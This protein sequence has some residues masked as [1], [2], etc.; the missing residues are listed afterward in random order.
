M[1]KNQLEK[2]YFSI[3]K[4]SAISCWFFFFRRVFFVFIFVNLYG[5]ETFLIAWPAGGSVMWLTEIAHEK[6]WAEY[7]VSS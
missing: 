1:L 6:T 5:F 2:I 4:K 3:A 7:Y